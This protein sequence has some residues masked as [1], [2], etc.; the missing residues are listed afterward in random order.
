MLESLENRRV[1]AT[2]NVASGF[3]FEDAV[4]A[5][6]QSV[7]VPDVIRI[8]SGVSSFNFGAFTPPITDSLEIIGPG[9]E[10][11][12]LSVDGNRF[13]LDNEDSSQIDVSISG[14]TI[15]GGT[16]NDDDGDNSD[17]DGFG[18]AIFN[19]E[20]LTL[21][22]VVIEN[23]SASA[24]GGGIYNLGTL[25][26]EDSTLSN[27]TA[28]S[29][30]GGILNY[31]GTVTIIDS[32]LVSNTA[33]FGGGLGNGVFDVIGGTASVIGSTLASNRSIKSG[34]GIYNVGTLSVTGSTFSSNTSGQ[35]G[36]GIN[37]VGSATI[38][39]ST[40]ANSIF[41]N[42]SINVDYSIVAGSV[43]RP[44]YTGHRIDGDHNIFSGNGL[45][46]GSDNLQST[47]PRLGPLAANGNPGGPLT[48]SLLADSPAID[49]G[50]L[51]VSG[52]PTTDQRG[53]FFARFA[54]GDGDGSSR[55]DIGAYEAQ[56]L[57]LVVNSTGDTDDGDIFNGTTTLREA[58]H[59]SNSATNTP[60]FADKITFDIPF[61]P[62]APGDPEVQRTINLAT[63]LP[64]IVDDVDISG[65]LN[66]HTIDAG[67]NA[68]IFD[69]DDGESENQINVSVSRLTLTGG[70]ISGDGGAIRNLENLIVDRSTIIGNTA[71][72]RGGGIYSDQ[73]SLTVTNSDIM[74]NS[75]ATNGGGLHT[76]SDS[77]V[78]SSTVSGNQSGNGAGIF[79]DDGTLTVTDT[80]VSSNTASGVGG[81]I[82]SDGATLTVTDS[83]V[84]GN[85]ATGNG[86][87]LRGNQGTLEVTNSTVTGNSSASFGGGISGRANEGSIVASTISGNTAAQD[88]GGIDITG[89]T[90]MVT[91]STIS[92]NSAT[93]GGGINRFNNS[94]LN[95]TRSTLS[96]NTASSNGG[97][98]SSSFSGST[99]ITDSTVSGNTAGGFG[100]G[101]VR[102]DSADP[103]AELEIV[104]STISA[105]EAPA[106]Q[107]SG[108]S[109]IGISVRPIAVNSSIIAGNVND[110]VFSAGIDFLSNGYN[111]IGTGDVGGFTE[112]GDQVGVDP[113]LAPLANNG[114]PTQTHALL[115]GSPALDAGDPS[116]ST[117]SDQRGV[118][119]GRSFDDPSADGEG[120]DIGSFERQSLIVVNT[121]DE[122]NSDLEDNSPG[123]SLREAIEIA[124]EQSGPDLITFSPLFDAH[125]TITL[126]S[127]LPEITEEL[128]IIGPGARLL[129]IDAGGG[130]DG[131][132]GNQNGYRHFQIDDEIVGAGFQ[133]VISDLTLT[134]GDGDEAGG[135]ILNSENLELHR[136]SITQ[137]AASTLGGGIHN[138]G[139]LLIVDSTLSDN[140]STL[141][142][143]AINSQGEVEIVQS[144]LSGNTASGRGGAIK[145]LFN[146]ANLTIRNSTISG[147]L[148]GFSGNG[149]YNQFGY[150]SLYSTIIADSLVTNLA[151][152][153]DGDTNLFPTGSATFG[154][155]AI[156]GTVGLGP[157]A[158]NGG[159]TDTH[160]LLEGS[161]AIDQGSSS[162]A[163][164]YRF[165]ETAGT[166]I[167]DEIG[168]HDGT[169]NG[170][171][172]LNV[173]GPGTLGGSAAAFD[174]VDDYISVAN[175]ISA[176][177]LSGDDY[178]VEFWFNADNANSQ[179]SLLA[180]TDA[181]G[182]HAVLIEIEHVQDSIRFLNRTPAGN[183][184]G[185]NLYSSGSLSADHLN[186]WNH[187][188]AVRD[189]DEMLLY[190]N[191]MLVGSRSDATGSI[192][193]DL[194]LTIGRIG[195]NVSARY[196]KG[197]MD[198]VVIHNRALTATEVAAHVSS[199]IVLHD[200]RGEPSVRD[201]G[202]GVDIGAVERQPLSTSLVVDDT[203]DDED[204]SDITA[205]D[206]S[207]REAIRLANVSTGDD[208]ITFSPDLF[209]AAQ[210]IHLNS[211]LP[212]ISDDLTIDGP[213]AGL[214]TIDAGGGNDG[215]IG[216]GFRILHID[217]GDSGNHID[218]AISGF[219]VTGGDVGG[220]SGGGILN[221]ENLTANDL[222]VRDNFASS[223]GGGI[224]N[225]GTLE[226][227][228]ST[229]S[230]NTSGNRGGG[231]HNLNTLTV[232]D[233]TLSENVGYGGGI[234]SLNATAVAVNKSTISGN[235]STSSGGGI[236]S[237]GYGATVTISNS[238]FTNNTATRGGGVD[239]VNSPLTISNTIVAANT[240]PLNADI[241]TSPGTAGAFNLI[242]DGQGLI[243]LIDGANGNQI[244]TTASPI[245]P[246]LGPLADN[247]G[248]TLTHALL[249]GSPA[250]DKI[251]SSQ[252]NLAL[253]GTA[254]Q[255]TTLAPQYGP[256][257]ANDGLLGNFTSTELNDTNPWWQVEL[258]GDQAISRVVL[259]N[260][261]N[262]CPSRLRDITVEI[263]DDVG[264][265]V[266][267]SP[268]LNPEN[269]LGGSQFNV[270][271]ETLEL[272][273][274]ALAG[275]ALTGRTVRVT[276]TA[277]PDSSGTG[278]VGG[279]FEQNALSLGEVEVFGTDQRGL[280][281]PFHSELG[282]PVLGDIGAFESQGFDFGDAPA[283][284]PTTL[285]SNGASHVPVGPQLGPT[286]D[287]DIDG[288]PSP[289]ADGDDL[290]GTDDEDGVL[291]G[292]IGPGSTMAAV[293]ILLE[294]ASTGQVDA[295]IDFNRD[296]IW[297]AGEK[298]IDNV[299]VNNAMQTLNFTVPGGL[300]AGDNIA[301]V[302]ISSAGGLDPF[303]PA[304]DGE[305]ED[306]KISIRPPL[307][308]SIVVN[309]GDTQRST[310]ETVQVTFD[311]EVNLD[312][313]TGDVF[314]FV[315]DTTG[316]TAIDVPV[317]NQVGGKTVVDFTF[318]PGPT[319]NAGGGL[320]DG[321]YV[322]N[323]DASRVTVNS[324]SLDGNGDGADG[325][326]FTFG[327]IP[328]DNFFRKYGDFNE[329]GIVD[330]LDFA[331]FRQ[332]FGKSDGEAGFMDPIDADSDDSIGLLDFA[333]F[334]Q[335]FGT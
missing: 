203:A 99:T 49:A 75:S 113:M 12:T 272:N 151:S 212:T 135:A 276:R 267:T 91:E 166:T 282:A 211:Q 248:P 129:T 146:L 95:V 47:N 244:G 17:G 46:N 275:T 94:T 198:E 251:D 124:E 242:G 9:A 117:G 271:P 25:T 139:K 147:N 5:A 68:R 327:A 226:L 316:Q 13:M 52:A 181:G 81:G 115:L 304:P 152:R 214:L 105:N 207:L 42:R 126:G 187:L 26:I 191:G 79:H 54:D 231:I 317:V 69:V 7:G 194:R 210:T 120:P 243:G 134:G 8:S 30:G 281:R 38:R 145:N 176:S 263:L 192:P 292:G 90:L 64:S 109:R 133:V 302:R 188:A 123:L 51:A 313:S 270:G 266:F 159:P 257:F 111:L 22:D 32:T 196:F 40:I 319:V 1:L 167:A 330:L 29:D 44:L 160:G 189:G 107:G 308:E 312:L 286:R 260:R 205:G 221:I 311:R 262:C 74:G 318:A 332:A 84:S 334:R 256:E 235:T 2:F 200:Q 103:L 128:T 61:D 309:G 62:G 97:G 335:N 174:G 67:G 269:V 213:G 169:T 80:Q 168:N 290:G 43:G 280:P 228:N 321:D 33:D 230:G 300:T 291:F 175:Q 104:R 58:I 171:V 137:N 233:S 283:G 131:T 121:S 37:N 249:A 178:T 237:V 331:A 289:D 278:G 31:G 199:G 209:N 218:V 219:T 98:L 185:Q 184:G 182:S 150:T 66:S 333:A 4:I 144:T 173:S 258:S 320:E 125:Q 122:S 114:G 250:L 153:V 215:T 89:A 277:D 287:I 19:R 136:V 36:P 83:V 65:S 179:Q 77:D 158:N 53:G 225:S 34:G 239:V 18:G 234:H 10:S 23:S 329:N 45:V 28:G 288:I 183:N 50:P 246:L 193:A 264:A 195:P 186:Q 56:P 310:I 59:F 154:T 232:T 255:S 279:A 101:I 71:S 172:D 170:A 140:R 305:V 127:Q 323:I 106:G 57:T 93:E 132:I 20:N 236:R 274:I 326:N 87:G 268:L 301:R 259:H 14:M 223:D 240:A 112:T 35:Q 297:D 222:I 96:N 39:H 241:T 315:N 322:L 165:E 149:I 88:G 72:G 202:N 116:A 86:G 155:N 73:G 11:F 16:A 143:G 130:S 295:W 217:D 206:L 119:F 328:L 76:G 163:A 180:L 141:E 138:T 227:S 162:V 284:Y 48:H 220:S 161:A 164:L 204:D 245:D 208:T 70:N 201:D 324:D 142:G 293:N 15:S 238:T 100:G 253:G 299:T 325:D 3:Q 306:Y 78:V 27:N 108:V 102:W 224:R 21:T 247:G 60:L 303:G 285:A 216:N 41:L 92:G 157:L 24:H 148:A 190:L 273:V 177:E 252:L 6:N 261:D 298:I 85:T 63:P 110:D 118:P 197:L 307:V 296:G 265:V 294:N 229:I 55:I 82:A 254:T 314:E 156:T